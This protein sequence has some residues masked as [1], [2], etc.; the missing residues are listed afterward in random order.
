M[1]HIADLHI[2]SSFSD[3]TDN[4]NELILKIKEEGVAVFSVTDHDTYEFYNNLNN[5]DLE[6]LFLI[7]GIEFSCISKAGK[8]HILGYGYDINNKSLKNTLFHSKAL[9]TDKLNNRLKWLKDN[10]NI[11][12]S[13]KEREYINSL[14]SVGKP[15]LA[16]ILIKRGLANTVSDAIEKYLSKIP[17]RQDRIDSKEAIDA[18]NISGGVPVWAHPLGGE[19]EKRVSEYEFNEQLDILIKEGIKGLECFYSR[20]NKDEIEFLIKTAEKN[21][22]YISGGSDYHGEVKNIPI[23]MLSRDNSFQYDDIVDRLTILKVLL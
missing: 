10:Y 6:G 18:I 20:Y 11:I 16:Q 17:E 19:G 3:G 4:V 12:L 23:G 7:S 2:H 5:V 9:R 21:N 15:H 1:C 22:L 14:S 8:C 13:E